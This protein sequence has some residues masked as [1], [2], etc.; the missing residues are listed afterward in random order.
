MATA[1]GG[2]VAASDGTDRT[3]RAAVIAAMPWLF[4]PVAGATVGFIMG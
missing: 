1:S 2:D 4:R 3:L